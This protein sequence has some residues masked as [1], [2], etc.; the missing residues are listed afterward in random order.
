[1]IS[2]GFLA[3][4]GLLFEVMVSWRFLPGY[5]LIAEVNG[6][7]I[8]AAQTRL[9]SISQTFVAMSV[10]NDLRANRRLCAIHGDGVA[11]GACRAGI[12]RGNHDSSTGR[13]GW[14][15]DTAANMSAA[16]PHCL[17]WSATSV[18]TMTL[19]LPSCQWRA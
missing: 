7:V 5:V 13:D 3:M 18:P 6:V 17:L 19:T 10:R 15:E 11:A 9:P 14:A 8:V 2:F 12:G 4:T 1:M 16:R